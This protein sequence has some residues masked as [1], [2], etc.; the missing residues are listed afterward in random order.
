MTKA[1]PSPEIIRAWF[2]T[3][4]NPLYD[5]FRNELR[6]LD[7][8][9]LAWRFRE[10]RSVIIQP[11][12]ELV[13]PDAEPNLEQFL[14]YEPEVSSELESYD[15][16]VEKLTSCLRAY[17]TALLGD[18][19]FRELLDRYVSE[20]NDPRLTPP[21]VRQELPDSFAEYVINNVTHLSDIYSTASSWNAHSEEFLACRDTPAVRG[22]REAT[23]EAAVRL[24]ETIRALL[25]HLRSLRNELSYEFGVP[26]FK[27]VP[28]Y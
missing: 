5:G 22:R 19:R 16:Q 18:A 21:A 8:S 13:H 15:G 17:H 7:N 1:T 26:I 20:I 25:N 23:E 6:H 2:D 24:T 4:L 28:T 3:V 10:R 9:N 14:D 27:P 12:R 11:Y